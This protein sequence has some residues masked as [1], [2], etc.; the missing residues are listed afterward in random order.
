M[1]PYNTS[2]FPGGMS[3]DLSLKI[4]VLKEKILSFYENVSRIDNS[5]RLIMGQNTSSGD[6]ED[7]FSFYKRS[8]CL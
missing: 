4:T 1:N 2:V 8:G 6:T 7:F 3:T 5:V